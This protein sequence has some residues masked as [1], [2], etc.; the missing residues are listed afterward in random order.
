M[1]CFF[2]IMKKLQNY[3]NEFFLDFMWDVVNHV[4]FTVFIGGGETETASGGTLREFLFG[5][6]TG[7]GNRVRD[8]KSFC[9][10][11]A[12][13]RF[14]FEKAAN[15]HGFNRGLSSMSSSSS[16]FTTY[17]IYTRTYCTE[18]WSEYYAYTTTIRFRH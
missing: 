2:V 13:L 12:I 1:F 5:L 10:L 17:L 14:F 7:C 8:G 15:F 16:Y 6:W 11:F 18:V 9:S 4:D 3:E